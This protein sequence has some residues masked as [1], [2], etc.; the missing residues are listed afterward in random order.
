[1]LKNLQPTK[2]FYYFEQICGI[3]HGSGNTRQ[4]SDYLVSFAK[5]HKLQ[6]FQDELNNVIIIKEATAGYENEPPI[7]VQGHMDMVAVK[8]EDCPIDMEK[9]GLK[10]GIEGDMI[11]AEGTSLGADDG[12]A[13]AYALALLDSEDISHP[14]LEVVLTVDEEVGMEGALFI[15]LSMLK[16]KR[17]LNIDSETQGELTVSCAGGVRVGGTFEDPFEQVTVSDM[18]CLLRI[19]VSGLTGGH[20]GTEI[21]HGRAN[22]NILMGR[23]LCGISGKVGFRLLTLEGGTKDNVI[24]SRSMSEILIKKADRDQIGQILAEYQRTFGQEYQDTDPDLQITA[25]AED[26]CGSVRALYTDTTQKL[27]EFLRHAK[28]GV[29]SMSRE[30]PDLVETSLNL[31]IIHTAENKLQIAYSI[32]SS[33]KSA[34]EALKQELCDGFEGVGAKVSLSGDYPAWELKKDS[35]L[36]AGMQS[37]Y[38]E[39]FGIKPVVL[40]IHAGLECGILAEKIEG[41]DSVSF[42]PDIHDIHTTRERLSISS[43]RNMWEYLVAIL[44]QKVS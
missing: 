27:L 12:I 19:E 14:R 21:H 32:R 22:A 34:K 9:E 10:L 43:A 6:Y 41:L 30:L 40:A 23:L 5:N 11:F 24:P 4:I 29:Q 20:S 37:L 28:N 31:G 26:A 33:S 16:G 13:V 8:E 42:G 38:Q 36:T 17:L 39:M 18:D 35:A 25:Q 2:V 7:I 1:M 15:D 3:P 44:G